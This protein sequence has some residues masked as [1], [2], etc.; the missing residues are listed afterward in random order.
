ME[1]KP[2]I[3]LLVTSSSWG[4]AERYVARLAAQAAKTFDVT[5]AAGRS[6]KHELF[7]AL[8]AEVRALEIP[9]L[10]QP[11]SPISDVLAVRALRR[12]IDRE[13]FDLIHTN[14]SKA[15]LIGALAARMSAYRPS[16]IYTA[17]GWG[18]LERRSLL[19]RLT[20]LLSEKLAARWRSATITLSEAERD[21]ALRR[22]LATAQTLA[23]IPLGIDR[24]EIAFLDHDDAR[25][26]LAE[27]CGTRLDR[28]VLGTI[29]NAYPA[30]NLPMLFETFERLAPDFPELDLV[31]LGDGPDMPR[32]R[33]LHAALPHKDR[34]CLPGAVKDAATLMKGFDVFV[35]PSTKEGLPWT[36][37]EASL[38]EIPIVATRVGALPEL[39]EDRRSGL[40]VEPGNLEALRRALHDVLTD[41]TLYHELKS[42]APR[43]AERRSG[44]AM[45]EAVLA[46]Y[47]SVLN[48]RSRR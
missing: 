9:E 6:P 20:L 18:F 15:G 7:S 5:V 36:I 41:R 1:S 4:G 29:A 32:L 48:R 21:V 28:L 22:R 47:R 23:I 46:L 42:G 39:I 8:P 35:L 13:R 45:V 27:R 12:L 24:E 19:F 16:V 33:A 2:K 14:S 38:A 44:S 40:L 17:H 11:I 26:R 3:L 37:L 30:K 25:E 31:V 43:I 10:R 34:V